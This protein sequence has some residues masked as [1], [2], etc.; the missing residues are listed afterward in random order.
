MKDVGEHDC[1]FPARKIDGEVFVGECKVCGAS[2][3]AAALALEAERDNLIARVKGLEAM[4]PKIPCC[5]DG[6]MDEPCSDMIDASKRVHELERL[7]NGTDVSFAALV[8]SIDSKQTSDE[9]YA[10]VISARRR[11]DKCAVLA[12][13]LWE[14]L[15]P[16]LGK[17]DRDL[18]GRDVDTV[19]GSK[20]LREKMA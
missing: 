15:S 8:E 17:A 19:L 10:L 4:I 1:K 11:A 2:V 6:F 9:V 20:K 16:M 3:A 13:R 18:Y 12:G 7:A 14:V 5:P